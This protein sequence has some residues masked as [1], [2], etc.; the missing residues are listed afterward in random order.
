MNTLLLID[1]N[2]VMHRAFHAIPP[3]KTKQGI[4]TNVLY[5]FFSML[6]KA[7]VDFSPSH[8]V[9]C[10]DTPK[11][12]FRNKLFKKYQAQRP[13]I[14][15]DFIVQIPSVKEALDQAGVIHLEK[16]GY[17]ADD[18][19][20]TIAEHYN[21]NDIKVLVLSGD[22]DI[23]QLV[24]GNIYVISP[25]GG[26]SNMTI[27]D[28]SEVQKKLGVTPEEI[29]DYKALAG[30]PADNYPGAKG[31][32]PKTAANLIKQFGSVENIYNNLDKIESPK[33]K[34]ILREN[35]DSVLLGKKLAKIITDVKIEFAIDKT[36]YGG[37]ND[38]LKDYLLKFEMKGLVSRLFAQK[39]QVKKT[40]EKKQEIPQ[41]SLF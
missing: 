39:K 29:P 3:F 9:V 1:G 32:G 2:A 14:D 15:D 22:K 12:T 18:L 21:K 35:K 10:F 8:V 30:D 28:R 25:Q 13:K 5:G 23:L 20:G 41:P 19:L 24:K 6:H 40:A 17:E 7:V 4:P 37:F 16:D 27:Y 33:I 36:K 11:P 31:I 34:Q 38:N 26:I